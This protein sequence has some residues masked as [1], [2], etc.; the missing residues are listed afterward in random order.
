MITLI[1]DFLTA[2]LPCSFLRTGVS[3]ATGALVDSLVDL[4]DKVPRS[5]CLKMETPVGGFMI[6]GCKRCRCIRRRGDH[7]PLEDDETAYGTLAEE[8]A[9]A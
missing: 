9:R 1:F 6:T 8:G 3:T 4:P 2:R 7:C 5:E